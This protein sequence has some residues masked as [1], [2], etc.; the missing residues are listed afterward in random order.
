MAKPNTVGLGEYSDD[1]L[2]AELK[3]RKRI[4]PEDVGLCNELEN[5]ITE[6]KKV[7]QGE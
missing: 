4:R 3:A 2:I 6:D 1:D 7:G 5:I